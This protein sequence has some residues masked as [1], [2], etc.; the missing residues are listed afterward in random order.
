[1]ELVLE[2]VAKKVEWSAFNAQ[3][4]DGTTGNRQ[5]R[6]LDQH[7]S[8]S[9]GNIVFHDT[10]GNGSGTAQKLNFDV[11]ADAM[12]K[13]YDAG[14]P[15]RNPVL[16][17]QP[18]ALLDL[19]KEMVNDIDNK[20][21]NIE[22]IK[23]SSWTQWLVGAVVDPVNLAT[24]FIPIART[25]SV[26]KAINTSIKISAGTVAPIEALRAI[27]VSLFSFVV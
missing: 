17:C 5:M 24:I 10:A 15:M 8:L 1:M 25:P 16:F 3:Y 21:K 27:T 23:N 26:W 6:G 14:A 13:L 20:F 22:T 12:K 9:G 18:T 4:N 7:C 11:I 19:N 2:T